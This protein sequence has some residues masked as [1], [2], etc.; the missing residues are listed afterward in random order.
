M[1]NLWVQVA[2]GFTAITA[3]LTVLWRKVI[4]P[5]F[6]LAQDAVVAAP[7]FRELIEAFGGNPNALVVLAAIA[8]EF[9]TDS[10]TTLRDVV[11]KLTD[12]SNLAAV[13]REAARQLSA[14]DRRLLSRLEIL[15]DILRVRAD[16]SAEERAEVAA[17]LAKA[18]AKVEGIANEVKASQE[19]ADSTEGTEAGEAADAAA[20]SGTTET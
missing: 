13:E 14:E 7:I 19:R 18:Q 16:M 1:D 12:A 20:R 9:R 3:A 11:N 5:I 8:K 17:N 4:K 6:F 15:L 10:G 2:V